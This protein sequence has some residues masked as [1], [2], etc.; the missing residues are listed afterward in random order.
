VCL[1]VAWPCCREKAL[2]RSFFEGLGDAV[3]A[4]GLSIRNGAVEL[5]ALEGWLTG[6]TDDEAAGSGGGSGDDN[7]D[8]D[9]EDDDGGDGG[10][11]GGLNGGTQTSAAAELFSQSASQGGTTGG[12][13]TGGA[14]SQDQGHASQGRGTMFHVGVVWRDADLSTNFSPMAAKHCVP[15]KDCS[16]WFCSCRRT[17]RAAQAVAPILGTWRS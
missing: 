16:R 2:P 11:S 5:A 14:G 6:G 4:E 17:V 3:G 10:R 13:S 15:S 12:G 8:D 9:D 1:C 7:D